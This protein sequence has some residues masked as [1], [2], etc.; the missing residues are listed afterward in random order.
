[1][2]KATRVISML[3]VVILAVGIFPITANAAVPKDSVFAKKS[4][5]GCS[6]ACHT[7]PAIVHTTPCCGPIMSPETIALEAVYDKLGS[8]FDVTAI[9]KGYITDTEIASKIQECAKDAT[10]A[11][12]ASPNDPNAIAVADFMNTLAAISQGKQQNSKMT[13]GQL[14]EVSKSLSALEN[15]NPGEMC[16]WREILE[17]IIMIIYILIFL[18]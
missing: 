11:L 16:S 9:L 15:S 3:L 1:M 14:F 5:G 7:N 10:E 8:D 6:C 4:S 2:K 13:V 12:R 17:D 18:C